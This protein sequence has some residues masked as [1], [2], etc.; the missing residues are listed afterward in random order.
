MASITTSTAD[1]NVAYWHTYLQY[2]TD[3]LIHELAMND[4]N[5][6]NYMDQAFTIGPRP[7]LNT[8]IA[9]I[10][11][12]YIT[13]DSKVQELQWTNHMWV[14]GPILGD[15]VFGSIG[16]YAQVRAGGAT[17]AEL[18]IGYQCPV[19]P[20][21][22][23]ESYFIPSQ[24]RWG[25]ITMTRSVH[26]F[27][28]FSTSC[29]ASITTS[30]ADPNVAYWRTYSQCPTDG[31]IHELLLNDANSLNYRENAFTIGPRPRFNTPI[32]A[33]N[34]NGFRE[35]STPM[36]CTTDVALTTLQIRIYYITQDSKVQELLLSNHTWAVGPILGDVV[37]GSIGLYAQ[38]RASG[39]TL[40]E[41]RVGYQCPANPNTITES[42]YI[43]SQSRWG[44]RT[45][46]S[47]M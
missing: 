33:V 21:T 10:R 18:R 26:I 4:A 27:P 2:P 46:P 11:V 7:R 25:N 35:A 36:M 15:V 3:G 24:S 37:F 19:N 29:I 40:A 39:A 42:Y 9:A 22:I 28:G 32:A 23:T 14:V 43:S 41:L 34:W 31:L 5:S 17:L 13:Q 12:Y 1:P 38:V 45:Y 16:L 8:P 47:M 20:N 6:L 44:V 30:T